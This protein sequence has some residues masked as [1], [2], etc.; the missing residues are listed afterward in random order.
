LQVIYE[1]LQQWR[2][3]GLWYILSVKLELCV[4]VLWDVSPV[5]M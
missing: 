1:E 5:F 3:V 4:V 2:N